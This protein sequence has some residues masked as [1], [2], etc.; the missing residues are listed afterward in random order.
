VTRSRRFGLFLLLASICLP[1]A[2]LPVM[3]G[4]KQNDSA[5]P[6][7]RID[8]VQ[9]DF[10]QEKR[11]KILVRPLLAKGLFVFQAP[12]NLR[13]EYLSPVHSL[14]LLHQGKIR[15]FGEH[16]GQMVEEPGFQADAMQVMLAEISTWLDGNFQDSETFTARFEN[17]KSVL[18]TPKQE[19][20][21]ALISRIELRLSEQPGLLDTVT[22]FEGPDSSTRLRF[23]HARLN[24]PLAES[25]FTQP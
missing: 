2:P 13:W 16:N 15:K 14:L 23:S 6:A 24:Q 12:G 17:K 1:L 8:S 22:I 11:L 21:R 7:L 10:S 5:Q 4:D 20:L 3:A 9:A 18:L 25:L 19:G